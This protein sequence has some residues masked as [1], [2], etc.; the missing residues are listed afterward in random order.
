VRSPA[1]Q[2][3]LRRTI[4]AY[5]RTIAL[6]SENVAAHHGLGLAYADPSW[7]EPLDGLPKSSIYPGRPSGGVVEE[8]VAKTEWAADPSISSPLRGARALGLVEPIG[9]LVERPRPESVSRLEPLH[10]VVERLG[11]A[12]ETEIDPAARAA[13]ARV[14]AAAHRAL[15]QWLKPDETAQG[16]AVALARKNDPAADQNAQSIVIHPLQRPAAPGL[17]PVMTDRKASDE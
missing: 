1:R 6:D 17:D 2:E 5:R 11:P 15:H 3:S 8:I 9:R 16:R 7:S 12:W 4:A 10:G 13:L 14:L